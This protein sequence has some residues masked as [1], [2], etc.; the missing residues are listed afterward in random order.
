VTAVVEQNT[1]ATKICSPEKHRH[2]TQDRSEVIGARLTVHVEFCTS[3]MGALLTHSSQF[4]VIAVFAKCAYLKPL[5]GHQH[6]ANRMLVCLG[7]PELGRGPINCVFTTDPIEG[8]TV[9]KVAGEA[10]LASLVCGATFFNDKTAKCLHLHMPDQLPSSTSLSIGYATALARQH[11]P[12]KIPRAA[13]LFF[14]AG[15]LVT[16]ERLAVICSARGLRKSVFHDALLSF[17]DSGSCTLGSPLE[18]VA[19]GMTKSVANAV[20]DAVGN[21]LIEL[22]SLL[23]DLIIGT[24]LVDSE[25]TRVSAA[26]LL[27]VGAG[28]TPAGDDFL[29]GVMSGLY[30]HQ[31]SAVA[32]KL[33]ALIEPRV[34]VATHQISAC[35]LEL[36]AKGQITVAS[37][38]IMA[39]LEHLLGELAETASPPF[40]S[41]ESLEHYC[42]Q[43]GSSSGYDFLAGLVFV[44]LV[45]AVVLTESVLQT[46]EHVPE[47]REHTDQLQ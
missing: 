25:Q 11:P 6:F 35:H 22:R 15:A 17:N 13:R 36:A 45:L 29:C 21:S 42:D 41:L 9:N 43:V 1:E 16:G 3:L 33:W 39:R 20:T 27:G 12:T 37:I 47:T 30:A 7:L 46:R 19:E 26:K 10:F 28:L 4:T 14:R 18:S 8:I 2:K 5:D 34:D 40:E 24:P 38:D 23:A 32:H 44:K 31:R